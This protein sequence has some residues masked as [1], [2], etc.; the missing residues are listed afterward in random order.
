M[1]KIQA[2]LNQKIRI[3]YQ[4]SS[5]ISLADAHGPVEERPGV[6]F[7]I[8]NNDVPNLLINHDMS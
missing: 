2:G 6:L 8:K 1:E 4:L 3:S 7:M 5:Y